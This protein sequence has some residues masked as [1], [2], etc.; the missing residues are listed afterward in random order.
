M[1]KKIS[2]FSNSEIGSTHWFNT[3]SG[4]ILRI[5]EWLKEHGNENASRQQFKTWGE[6]VYER[7]QELIEWF[8]IS[9]ERDIEYILR[10]MKDAI[11]KIEG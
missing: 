2:Q 3:L 6:M 4:S 8:N 5:G 1:E 7:Q 9:K 10:E 11:K